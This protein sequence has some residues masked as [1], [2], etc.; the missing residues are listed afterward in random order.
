MKPA[1]PDERVFQGQNLVIAVEGSPDMNRS[2]GRDG[3]RGCLTFYVVLESAARA[4]DG[5]LQQRSKCFRQ[6]T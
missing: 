2:I 3:L 6:I 1:Y 5:S 4:L